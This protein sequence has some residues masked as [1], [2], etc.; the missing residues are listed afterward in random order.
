[1]E[2]KHFILLLMVLLLIPLFLAATASTGEVRK[3]S[4]FPLVIETTSEWA[5]VR[6]EGAILKDVEVRSIEGRNFKKPVTSANAIL[7]EKSSPGREYG[8]VELE[9]VLDVIDDVVSVLIDKG[10]LGTVKAKIPGAGEFVNDRRAK[11]VP[12]TLRTNSEWASVHFDGVRI[13]NA[14]LVDIRGDL[15]EPAVYSN[16][17]LLQ[18]HHPSDT[19]VEAKYLLDLVFEKEIATITIEKGDEEGFAI[20]DMGDLGM[21]ENHRTVNAESTVRVPFS[22]DTTANF[23][24]VEFEGAEITEF[25]IVGTEGRAL[26]EK[27]IGRDFIGLLFEPGSSYARASGTLGLEFSNDTAE[28]E[29]YKEGKGYSIVTLGN[30]RYAN[31]VEWNESVATE[32]APELNLSLSFRIRNGSLELSSYRVFP[33]KEQDL[34]RKSVLSSVRYP[35]SPWEIPEWIG[36]AKSVPL[37]I[38]TTSDHNVISFRGAYLRRARVV[39]GDGVGISVGVDKIN[40]TYAP[41]D[42]S[43]KRLV[44][45]LD[46]GFYG[47]EFEISI[48]K[49]AFGYTLVK[50]GDRWYPNLVM[51]EESVVSYNVETAN[52]SRREKEAPPPRVKSDV[53]TLPLSIET[54]S[55]WTEVR[56]EGI[57]ILDSEIKSTIGTITLQAVGGNRISLTKG[58]LGDDSLAK[59]D[60]LLRLRVASAKEPGK[61]RLIIEKGDIGYTKVSSD[62]GNFVNSENVRGDPRNTKSFL[63]TLPVATPPSIQKN[64][65]SN[66]VTYPIYAPENRSL[67]ANRVEYLLS[68]RELP[69]RGSVTMR[70]GTKMGVLSFVG[71]AYLLLLVAGFHYWRM[72]LGEKGKIN[73]RSLPAIIGRG[74]ERIPA[75]SFYVL[76]ALVLLFTTAFALMVNEMVAEALA[77]TAY[78]FLVWGV[79]LRLFGMTRASERVFKHV[80]SRLLMFFVKSIAILALLSAG[81][82]I[83]Y[84]LFGKKG[85]LVSSLP[86]IVALCVL[87]RYVTT[88]L[89]ESQ[90]AREW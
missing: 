52:L 70:P 68:S 22:V 61:G 71:M 51:G 21:F 53:I 50:L 26:K 86:A 13:A 6:F 58:V 27:Y 2:N 47:K 82:A 35:L 17:V 66:P 8:K 76:F 56:F 31:F 64:T 59:V 34:S 42:S 77:T 33:S 11:R 74:F 83:G 10:D 38:E 29:I 67:S 18:R 43:Y 14:E 5:E 41:F 80:D 89:D 46:V 30:K 44:F 75:G 55:D 60:F 36:E 9:V 15:K 28:I 12:F 23:T 32:E 79:T 4:R 3:T 72:D 1:L 73:L 54:T 16:Y 84:E 40:I 63:F 48:E 19:I 49:G 7:V 85:L 81:V 25:E 37:V 65:F 90:H 78:F 62:L 20:V 69:G 39:E 45:N 87:F 88:R 57:E 24:V